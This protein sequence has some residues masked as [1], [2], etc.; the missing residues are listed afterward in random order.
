MNTDMHKQSTTSSSIE[1]ISSN[2]SGTIE[3]TKKVSACDSLIE[4]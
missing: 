3:E 4:E 2:I 1:M